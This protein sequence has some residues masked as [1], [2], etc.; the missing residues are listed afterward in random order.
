MFSFFAFLGFVYR[1]IIINIITSQETA[2]IK[3]KV[4]VKLI[5]TQ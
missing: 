4:K 1:E 2:A 5:T 3:V